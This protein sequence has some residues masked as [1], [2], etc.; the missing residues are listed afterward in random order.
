MR[1]KANIVNILTFVL[2]AAF[3]IILIASNPSI[4]GFVARDK[5]KADREVLERLGTEPEVEVIVFL[6]DDSLG[7]QDTNGFEFKKQK[8]KQKQDS[9]LSKLD[10]E[11]LRERDIKTS[12]AKDLK[13]KHRY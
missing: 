6:K 8:I 12:S 13:L 9:V 4:T 2:V 7:V 1:K 5:E 10:Y 3:G 11:D